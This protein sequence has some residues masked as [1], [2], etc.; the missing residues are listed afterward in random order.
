MADFIDQAKHKAEELIGAARGEIGYIPDN[1]GVITEL[2]SDNGIVVG[3]RVQVIAAAESQ[4]DDARTQI[5]SVIEDFA[6]AVIVPSGTGR[7]WAPAKRW[8]IALDDGRLVFAAEGGL[9]LA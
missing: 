4:T 3:T 8:A 1:D 7:E 6:D 5:G 2:V 9:K